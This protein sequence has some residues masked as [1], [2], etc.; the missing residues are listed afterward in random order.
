[1]SPR[2]WHGILPPPRGQGYYDGEYDI[3][4]PALPAIDIHPLPNTA[5]LKFVFHD[6]ADLGVVSIRESIDREIQRVMRALN[7]GLDEAAT[8]LV[9]A[10]LRDKGYT[11]LEPGQ[12]ERDAPV[13]TRGSGEYAAPATPHTHLMNGGPQ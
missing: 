3:A 9:I 12:A 1:M 6:D 7:Q 8:A 11:I 10:H 2:A 13:Q 4:T 5:D